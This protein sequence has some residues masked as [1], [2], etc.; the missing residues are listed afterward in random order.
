MDLYISINGDSITGLAGMGC[1]VWV[2]CDSYAM[3]QGYTAHQTT[4]YG[5]AQISRAWHN[6]RYPCI[7]K[8]VMLWRINRN[9]TQ[10][11]HTIDAMA[12]PI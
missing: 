11:H 2:S 4:G 1:Y 8:V 9:L 5:Q 3:K 12:N 7:E 6:V 10:V